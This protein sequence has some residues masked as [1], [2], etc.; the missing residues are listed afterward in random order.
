M[1]VA[2]HTRTTPAV[3]PSPDNTAAYAPAPREPRRV[4]SVEDTAR[5][6][7]MR[8]RVR[9]ELAGSEQRLRDRRRFNHRPPGPLRHQLRHRHPEPEQQPNPAVMEW[10]DH[11]SGDAAPGEPRGRAM[12][13]DGMPHG[14]QHAR[15]SV[16]ARHREG[17]TTPGTPSCGPTRDGTATSA[18]GRHDAPPDDG[19]GFGT[20]SAVGDHLGTTRLARGQTTCTSTG[21]AH[22]AD[23]IIDLHRWL[24]PRPGGQGVAGSNPVV[25]TIFPQVRGQ[26]IQEIPWPLDRLTVI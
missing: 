24:L 14:S 23:T 18:D 15:S 17:I 7:P 21:R 8:T 10:I 12:P 26:V 4:A 1:C 22:G 2:T 3:G 19:S 16:V 20:K 25:P 9:P 13:V 11:R 6:C 5:K